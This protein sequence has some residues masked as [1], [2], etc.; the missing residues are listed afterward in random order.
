MKIL[1]DSCVWGGCIPELEASGH[2]ISWAGSW[3][4]DPGDLEI[5]Q[6]AHAE[7]RVLVTL[8]KDFGSAAPFVRLH[9]ESS[10]W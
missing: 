7:G 4:A 3:E 2:D 5:L 10:G 6:R 9:S 8:D 1:L